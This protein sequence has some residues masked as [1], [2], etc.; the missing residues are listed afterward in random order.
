M[1]AK[2]EWSVSEHNGGLINGRTFKETQLEI[3]GP[4]LLMIHIL[5]RVLRQV[6]QV[7]DLLEH[8]GCGFPSFGRPR[9]PKYLLPHSSAY[10]PFTPRI[11]HW[12]EERPVHG[13]TNG[14]P[15]GPKSQFA[16]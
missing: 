2:K 13:E 4:V 6:W 12:I 5:M 1:I 16:Q 14:K 15:G 11:K 8:C 10:D 9:T 3:V 7:L